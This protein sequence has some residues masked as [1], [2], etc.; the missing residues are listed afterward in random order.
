MATV[1]TSPQTDPGSEEHHSAFVYRS[2]LAVR[3]VPTAPHQ[4]T[5][6]IEQLTA[7]PHASKPLRGFP[8]PEW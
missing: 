8:R 1:D 3:P 5:P 4:I 7:P 6:L 2:E